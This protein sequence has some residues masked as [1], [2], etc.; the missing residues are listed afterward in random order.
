M[1]LFSVLT[2]ILHC[3]I[4]RE[5]V[6]MVQWAA[7]NHGL[8]E[9]ILTSV[10]WHESRLNLDP[11]A[12]SMCGVRLHGS[13]VSDPA[14]SVDIA[15]RSLVRRY[16][17]CRSWPRALAYYRTGRGCRARDNTH[18]ARSILRLAARIRAMRRR[19]G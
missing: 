5:T 12:E 8:S 19:R 16:N 2:L 6:A 13:Y 3:A 9:S 15:A 1:T 11:A 18:Y 10:C 7:H 4:P 17:E 14:E